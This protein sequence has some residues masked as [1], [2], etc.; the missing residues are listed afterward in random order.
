MGFDQ[1]C[2]LR[3]GIAGCGGIG[4]K[5]FGALPRGSLVVSC[6]S[7]L[8]RAVA[9]AKKAGPQCVAVE[10]I[11]DLILLRPT[12]VIVS[13]TNSSLASVAASCIQAGIHV[14]V[15][16]PVGLTVSEIELLQKLALESGVCVRAGYN[17]RFHPAILKAREIF[18]SGA[19]GELMF[20]RARYGHGGRLGYDREWRADP[21][22]SGGGELIDQGVHLIDLCAW[23]LGRWTSIIGH[24]AT[25]F[26]DMPVEDNAFLQ[27]QNE[28]GN[29]AWLHV[30]CTEWKNLFSMEIYGK[31]AK[32]HIEGLGGSYGLERLHFYRMLPEM[33]PPETVVYEYP[34]G[35]DSWGLE[36][37]EFIEDIRLD[38]L[39]V[40]GLLE[41]K[42]ALE[43]VEGVYR[44]QRAHPH[45]A[46]TQI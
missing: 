31:Q 18:D 45:L 4:L 6:D 35:D 7:S 33:G 13:T 24:T 34:R 11:E 8:E 14:L 17:H 20:I 40:P 29:V 38:R 42:A 23:F 39:P 37:R 25:Y 19:L 12:A 2:E 1:K 9:L 16:K 46:L 22:L 10:R 3:F 5:R 44:Q 32:L 36:T 15:E 21:R 41:A 43:V 28:A 27:L 26:W 30:S